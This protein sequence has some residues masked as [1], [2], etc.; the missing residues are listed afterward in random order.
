MKI[1][2]KYFLLGMA[3][4]SVVFLAF[5]SMS[6]IKQRDLMT[7]MGA[8]GESQPISTNEADQ[9]VLEAETP[10]I[11]SS[12]APT[13]TP[14]LIPTPS[15][16]P[17]PTPT[18]TPTLIPTSTPT[19]IPTPPPFDAVSLVSKYAQEYGVDE[20]ILFTIGQCESGFDTTS[21]NGPYGGIYQFH[22]STWIS[23]RNL[24]GLDPDP[25]LRFNPEE[26]IRTAAFKLAKDGTGAWPACSR[27]LQ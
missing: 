11:A 3:A 21:V 25:N 2:L 26:S 12:F 17:K 19:V 13:L 15:Q 5:I 7:A 16:A 22:H 6:N 8:Q 18:T 9:T 23:I 24:M 1:A 10:I 14:S 27:D 4:G 20:E